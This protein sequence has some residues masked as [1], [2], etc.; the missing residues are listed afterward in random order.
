MAAAAPGHRDWTEAEWAAM[1]D[2]LPSPGTENAR[3]ESPLGARFPAFTGK[4]SYLESPP[5]SPKPVNKWTIYDF[6]P[7]PSPRKVLGEVQNDL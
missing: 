3:L 7:S 4:K 5:F 1:R 2:G 6:P